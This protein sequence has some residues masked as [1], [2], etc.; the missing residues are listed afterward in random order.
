MQTLVFMYMHKAVSNL[1]TE[2]VLAVIIGNNR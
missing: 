2:A 1:H